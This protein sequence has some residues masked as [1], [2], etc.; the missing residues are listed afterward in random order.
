MSNLLARLIQ[1]SAEDDKTTKKKLNF[2]SCLE[3]RLK[4]NTWNVTNKGSNLDLSIAIFDAQSMCDW[5][6][7]NL[8]ALKHVNMTKGG[9]LFL[10]SF[11]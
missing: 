7:E 2:Q 8:I 11:V 6:E 3:G 4:E 5:R 9:R 10:E 1:N